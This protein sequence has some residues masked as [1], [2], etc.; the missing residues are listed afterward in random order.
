M[1]KS[2]LDRLLN[3]LGA[4]APAGYSVGLV[5]RFASPAVFRMTYDP[6]WTEY[7]TSNQLGFKDPSIA[8]GFS[9]TGSVRWSEI[10]MPDTAGI[11]EKARGFGLRYGVTVSVGAIQDRSIL[12]AAHSEREF[13]DDEIAQISENLAELHELIM[14][15]NNLTKAQTDAIS[16]IASGKLYAQ[17]SNELGISESALK[18]RLTAARIRIGAKNTRELIDLAR[19]RGLL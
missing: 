6:A 11:F 9:N 15:Q 12:G 8:W 4:I 14:H 16:K 5:I 19:Q 10:D 1:T 17:V 7:Y 3:N 13:R 2:H 18:A